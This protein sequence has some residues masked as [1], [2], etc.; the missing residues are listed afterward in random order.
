MSP[1]IM[2]PCP[3]A[4]RI[5]IRRRTK[6]QAATQTASRSQRRRTTE[7]SESSAAAASA[8]SADVV[9]D[10]SAL[11]VEELLS[12]AASQRRLNVAHD[13]EVGRSST[14][15]AVTRNK[16]YCHCSTVALC[17]FLIS[18]RTGHERHGFSPSKVNISLF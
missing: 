7:A 3:A 11:S 6:T 4:K 9:R 8:P 14:Q 18:M 17:Y 1:T 10:P 5:H 16:E 2:F 15:H 13:Q 12:Q